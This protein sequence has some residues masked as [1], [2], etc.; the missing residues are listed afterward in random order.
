MRIRDH[1]TVGVSSPTT[2][3]RSLH[4][5]KL[6][7]ESPSPYQTRRRTLTIRH[8][9]DHRI[10]ALLEVISPGNQDRATSVDSF[11]NKVE[12]CARKRHSRAGR[13]LVSSG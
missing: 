12:S 6:V 3:S 13:R 7:A 11:V 8:V 4:G 5:R 1:A 2:D 9:S 10:V